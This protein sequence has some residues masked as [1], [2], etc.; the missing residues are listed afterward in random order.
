M[1]AMRESARR[2]DRENNEMKMRATAEQICICANVLTKA[3]KK[4]KFAMIIGI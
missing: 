4:R 3:V 1:V 2:E